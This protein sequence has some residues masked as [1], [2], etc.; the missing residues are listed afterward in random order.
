MINSSTMKAQGVDLHR[1][2][3]QESFYIDRRTMETLNVNRGGSR[4]RSASAESQ[5]RL[6]SRS[7]SSSAEDQEE[8]LHSQR[9]GDSGDQQR[10]IKEKICIGGESRQDEL[11]DEKGSRIGSS[12]AE[13][14]GE[15][16]HRQT[17]EG[18]SGTSTAEDPGETCIGGASRQDQL[19]DENGRKP[20]E[21]ENG[22]KRKK[23]KERSETGRTR[24]RS[25]TGRTEE[26]SE[27]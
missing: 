23:L 14:P 25:E 22:R 5:G 18:R 9:K 20:D 16:L 13:D 19:I 3:I 7:G 11:I 4:S 27:I 26:R 2:R 17:E 8:L 21:L 10:R 6:T 24:E 1:Q 15:I 12:S